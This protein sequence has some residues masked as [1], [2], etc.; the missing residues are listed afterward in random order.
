VTAIAFTAAIFVTAGAWIFLSEPPRGLRVLAVA[1]GFVGV[2][3]VLRPGQGGISTGLMLALL[4]ALLT[5]V[6]QLMLK[7]MSGRDSTET[8]VAWNLILTVPIALVPA[9]LFWKAPTP[10]QWLLLAV[11]GALGALTMGLVTR[12][13]SLAEASLIVPIDFLRLPIVAFLAFA[14]FGQTV[15]ETTWIGGAVIFL[16]TVIMTRTARRRPEREI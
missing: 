15:P 14:I 8:L 11:Q 12:A 5:A 10:G 16:A 13:F 7:P 3:F 2:L 9:L 4:G 6:I 1:V